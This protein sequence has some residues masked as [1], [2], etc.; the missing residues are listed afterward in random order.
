[1]AVTMS[2]PVV[3]VILVMAVTMMP[4]RFSIVR[5]ILILAVFRPVRTMLPV[6]LMRLH[7]RPVR[8]VLLDPFTTVVEPPVTVVPT[9]LVVPIAVVAP[10]GVV[11]HPLRM[12]VVHPV[13]VIAMPPIRIVPVVI[14]VVGAH[15]E[16]LVPH[17]GVLIQPA[18]EAL[19][20]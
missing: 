14:A 1:M 10:R 7:F 5:L 17:V 8:M 9:V 2:M 11:T 16:R 15:P 13:G 6:F 20:S 3:A 12:M 19:M 4:F 18:D